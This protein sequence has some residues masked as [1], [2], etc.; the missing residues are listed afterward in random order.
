M[1]GWLHAKS[2]KKYGFCTIPG[3]RCN[4][5][6]V[7]SRMRMGNVVKATPELS[8]KELKF[9]RAKWKKLETIRQRRKKK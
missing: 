4:Q 5:R 8:D 7:F 1:K 9:Y 2:L 6:P 3:C